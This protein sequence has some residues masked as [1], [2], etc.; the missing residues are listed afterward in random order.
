MRLTPV[1][2]ALESFRVLA[3]TSRH[4][5]PLAAGGS[6]F[7]SFRGRQRSE[8]PARDSNFLECGFMYVS[9]KVELFLVV[10]RIVGRNNIQVVLSNS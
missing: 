9:R 10:S 4:D 1:A 5:R 6:V 7:D 3:A 8:I 2:S